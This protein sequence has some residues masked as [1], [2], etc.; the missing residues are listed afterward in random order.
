MTSG[1]ASVPPACLPPAWL[2]PEGLL[3]P[4]LRLRRWRPEDRAPFAALNADPEVM[5]FFP[6]PLTRAESDA[7]VERIEARWQETGLGFAVAER[8]ADGAFLGMVGLSELRLACPVEGATEIGWRLARAHWGQGYATEAA[9]AWRD[10]ALGPLGRDRL[11]AITARINLP[12]QAVMHRIGLRPDP[13]L[14]F[15]HPALPEGHPLRDHV[16]FTLSGNR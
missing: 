12:S 11:V 2:P 16:T 5:R 7:L 4:R 14:D 1:P 6:A 3:T 8:R 9:R 10:T 13:A 15:A